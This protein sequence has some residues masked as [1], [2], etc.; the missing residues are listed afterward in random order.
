MTP[1][2]LPPGGPR[3]INIGLEGFALDLERAGVPVAHVDW[4]PPAGGDPQLTAALARLDGQ[5]D[6]IERAN[7]D[8]FD[9]LVNGE[10]FLID[11]RPAREALALTERVVLHAGPPLAWERACEPM[12]AAILCAIRYEG[13]ARDEQEGERLVERGA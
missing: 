10:P 12:R 6:R 4:R 5:R 1:L 8:A 9:R 3:V 7:A 2:L 11:C 13:W